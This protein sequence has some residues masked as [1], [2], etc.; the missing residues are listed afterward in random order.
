MAACIIEFPPRRSLSRRT[1]LIA[2]SYC[3][4]PHFTV[5]SVYINLQR[6][7]FGKEG[8]FAGKGDACILESGGVMSGVARELSRLK[9]HKAGTTRRDGAEL[10]AQGIKSAAY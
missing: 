4:L 2:V 10:A 7:K 6:E 3:R 9:A 1:R 5:H 8:E